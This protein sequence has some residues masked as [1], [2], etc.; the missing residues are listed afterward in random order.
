MSRCDRIL[1][2]TTLKP[3]PEV[4]EDEDAALSLVPHRSRMGTFLHSLRP[5]NIRA[6]KDSMASFDTTIP[7]VHPFH[8]SI[9]SSPS[10]ATGET[11]AGYVDISNPPHSSP[12]HITSAPYGLLRHSKSTDFLNAHNRPRTHRSPTQLPIFDEIHS[13]SRRVSLNSLTG[14]KAFPRAPHDSPSEGDSIPPPVPPK[15]YLPSPTPVTSLWKSLL[16][17]LRDGPSQNTPPEI[18]PSPDTP[19]PL[20]PRKGDVVCLGYDTLDDRQMRRLEGRSDH[21]PVIGSYA[22]FI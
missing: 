9:S 3:D 1:W 7:A 2:K 21:R 18:Q 10:S 22:L 13:R 20:P 12:P 5:T 19:P 6:R 14:G 4:D 15:D 11:S 17:F 8:D 16:P